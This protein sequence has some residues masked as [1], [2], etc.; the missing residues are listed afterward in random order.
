MTAGKQGKITRLAC[1]YGEGLI[2]SYR[3]RGECKVQCSDCAAGACSASC[4]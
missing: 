1:S 4:E 3:S 2:F